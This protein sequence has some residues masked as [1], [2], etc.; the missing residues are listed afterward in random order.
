MDINGIKIII[1]KIDISCGDPGSIVIGMIIKLII[2][3]KYEIPMSRIGVL[4]F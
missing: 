4:K 1:L 2:S 3:I